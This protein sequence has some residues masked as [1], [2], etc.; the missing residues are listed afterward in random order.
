MTTYAVYEENG[1]Y[2]LSYFHGDFQK[3]V[4]EPVYASI[5]IIDTDIELEGYITP[6]EWNSIN[7]FLMGVGEITNHVI[8]EADGKQGMFSW[9]NTV[10]EFQYERI[11]KLS[12]RHYL[13]KKDNIYTLYDHFGYEKDKYPIVIEQLAEIEI[14]GKLTLTGLMKVLADV[15]PNALA[16]LQKCL[17][18][19]TNRVVYTS[20][21]RIWIGR[22]GYHSYETT[23]ASQKAF[24]DDDFNVTM[25][26]IESG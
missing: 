1:K 15:N 21:Y 10:I 4:L 9:G 16:E 24:I 23:A 14:K 25:L 18:Q 6:P 19:D 2:G 22:V 3:V 13:C 7:N 12:W 26:A 8:V 5:R 20:K 11:I 17:Y